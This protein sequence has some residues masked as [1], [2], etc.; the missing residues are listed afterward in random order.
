MESY[1]LESGLGL[2]CPGVAQMVGQNGQVS[3]V[4]L[5]ISSGTFPPI[6]VGGS[7]H[8]TNGQSEVKVTCPV[9]EE[10]VSLSQY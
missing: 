9:M 5:S 3:T 6:R 10:P 8:I 4:V 1:A 2:F 7:F